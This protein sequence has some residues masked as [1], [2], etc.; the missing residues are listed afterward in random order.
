[1]IRR[2]LLRIIKTDSP[3]PR[4]GW[5]HPNSGTSC[6]DPSPAYLPGQ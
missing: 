6:D 5:L 1:M 2:L 3:D 4:G